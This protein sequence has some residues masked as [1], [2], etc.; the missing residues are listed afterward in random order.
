MAGYAHHLLAAEQGR[1][2]S[3]A[4]V[5]ARSSQSAVPAGPTTPERQERIVEN[6]LNIA[7]LAGDIAAM[8]TA[9]ISLIVTVLRHKNIRNSNR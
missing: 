3:R 5:G 7:N 6:A 1:T 8:T 9:V 2:T 4:P